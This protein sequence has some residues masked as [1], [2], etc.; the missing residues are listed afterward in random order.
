MSQ[1]R[2]TS[3]SVQ[4]HDQFVDVGQL[5]LFTRSLS[6]REQRPTIVFLH[7]SLGS[8]AL[9]R[10]FPEK[11]CLRTDCNGMIYDRQGYGKSC[12]FQ[13]T[14]TPLYLHKEADILEELLCRMRINDTI[15]FGHSDGGSIALIGAALHGAGIR[16]VITEG[17]HVFVEEITLQGIREAKDALATT[18]LRQRVARYHKEKTDGVLSNWIDTWLSP[19][20]HDFN[21]EALLP[22]IKCPVLAIQGLDD[23]FGTS[24]QV[25]AIAHQ[26]GPNAS[27]VLIE[28]ARHTPH[29]EAEEATLTLACD[30]IRSK[31]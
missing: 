23:Q 1:S 13:E 15:L 24:K 3:P 22:S 29:K 20:F 4:T 30:F 11:L 19:E 26:S 16:G 14:R 9:W 28:H 7:D 31:C 12:H 8:V 6:V 18:N 27:G 2:E 10:D 17:A 25:D 5:R 21:I